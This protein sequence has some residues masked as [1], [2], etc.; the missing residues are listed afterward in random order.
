MPNGS[1]SKASTSN[2][3]FPLNAISVPCVPFRRDPEVPGGNLPRKELIYL[4]S[5]YMRIRQN[6]VGAMELDF[7][8]PVITFRAISVP[9]PENSPHSVNR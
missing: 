8:K 9:F 4:K 3:R 1:F 5:D 7:D 2:T 6:S